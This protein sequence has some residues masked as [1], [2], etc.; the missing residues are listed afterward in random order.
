MEKINDVF[1]IEGVG[2]DSNV[3]I[4]HDMI[5]DTG[6]GENIQ[7]I[8]NS[9][10]KAGLRVEDISMVLNT[11]CHFD[12][13]GGNPYF[14][15]AKIAIHKDD[16]S[17]LEESDGVKTLGFMFKRSFE[18]MKVDVY[19]NEGDRIGNFEVIHTPGHTMGSICLYDGEILICGDT[20]FANGG[21]GR[22]DLGGDLKMMQKSLERL[23]KLDIE[24]LLPGHG[25][26]VNNGSQHV[27]WAYDL[28]KEF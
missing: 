7:Y 23:S 6:T 16:A 27:K 9:V 25:P 1:I 8:L 4:I 28:L 11:H 24:Y 3:Y 20:V 21:F 17:A 12:H 19:L 26:W 18:P 10:K 14:P 22:V 5:V 13:T 15:S 2:F